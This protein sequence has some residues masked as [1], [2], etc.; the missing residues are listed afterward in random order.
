MYCT[1]GHPGL[2][3]R[4]GKCHDATYPELVEALA[5]QSAKDYIADGEIVAFDDGLSSFSRLQE[6]W[7][8]SEPEAA[9]ASGV[10]VYLYL[11]DLLYL[12]GYRLTKLTLRARKRV[13]NSAFQFSDPLRFTAHRNEAGEAYHREACRKGWEGV[14]AK[15]AS[16]PYAGK[17]SRQWQKL[18]CF[19]QQEFV[20]GGYTDPEGQ[21]IGFG[22]LL[23]GYYEG[24]D[25]RY[26]GRVGTGFDEDQLR[27]LH[28]TMAAQEQRKPAFAD[29]DVYER[30]VHW[31]RPELVAEVAFTEWTHDARLR[32][33]QFLGLREDKAARDVVR[34]DSP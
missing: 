13:L 7:G 17:R 14:I 16:S 20:I 19:N 27:D 32:H 28:A 10:A 25:L 3:S 6:R 2:F 4:N 34:E 11:F 26:A 18:K 8:I 24:G 22:A 21:R 23:V 31:I 30:G 12:D 9:R 33:P 29:E 1:D 5:A 15:R